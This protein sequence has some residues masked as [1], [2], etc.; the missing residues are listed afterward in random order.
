MKKT[1]FSTAAAFVLL[2]SASSISY[3]SPVNFTT[4]KNSP[5]ISSVTPLDLIKDEHT[6]FNGESSSRFYY[7]TGKD[8]R[9]FL[10]NEGSTSFSYTVKLPNGDVLDSGNLAP[11][12]QVTENHYWYTSPEPSLLQ[13]GNYTVYIRNSD[14]STGSYWIAVRSLES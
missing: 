3:A 11:G 12:Q 5:V 1:L 8:L 14:G 4:I 6:N 9:I 7:T 10:K 2:G 13:T